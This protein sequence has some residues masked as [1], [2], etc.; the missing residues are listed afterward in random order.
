MGGTNL[1]KTNMKYHEMA[2]Q[3]E[4]LYHFLR[5]SVLEEI[6][7]Q[8]VKKIQ[9]QDTKKDRKPPRNFQFENQFFES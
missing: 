9:P 7:P 2:A 1:K 5:F 8:I 6:V 3:F 4:V